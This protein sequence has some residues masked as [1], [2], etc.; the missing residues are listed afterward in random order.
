MFNEYFHS[1]FTTEDLGLVPD[2]DPYPHESFPDIDIT[3]HSV[4]NLLS[5]FKIHKFS[6]PDDVSAHFLKATATEITPVLTHLF[7]Q[8]LSDGVLPLIWKRAH[9][10]PIFKKGNRSDPRNYCPVS[11]TSIVCKTMEHILYSQMTHHFESNNIL[12]DVQFGFRSHHSCES[13]LLITVNDLVRAPDQKVQTDVDFSKAFDR[14]SHSRLLQKLHYYGIWG[15]MLR[16][17]RALLSNRTQQVMVNGSFSS[18][19][20]V[21]SG[22]PQGSVL[23]PALFLIYINDITAGIKSQIRLFAD[24]CLIYRSIYSPIDHEIL[25]CDLDT[26]SCWATRWK[27]LFNVSK[28]S[29]LQI[30]LAFSFDYYIDGSLLSPVTE[31]RYLGIL[32]HHKMSWHHHT[33]QLS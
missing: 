29:V 21:T 14:V 19:C 15:S 17:L 23:G 27:M 9:V 31:H 4:Y 7:R 12:V 13:Q 18:L 25:Q 6:G 32:L 5:N 2:M 24:D 11:L 10:C 33:N 26:L 8:S 22:V 16:W 28:C 20:T 30:T 1:V 3:T